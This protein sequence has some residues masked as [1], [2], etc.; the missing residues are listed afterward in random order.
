MN[1]IF[2]YYFLPWSSFVIFLHVSILFQILFPFRL[3]HNI[4]QHSL[5]YIVGLCWLSILNISVRTNIWIPR[6]RSGGG[7]N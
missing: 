2:F 6:G 3:L 7:K 4:E 1:F 5:Y